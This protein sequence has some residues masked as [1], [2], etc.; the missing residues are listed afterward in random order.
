MKKLVVVLILLLPAPLG[1]WA[2]DD[3]S[4]NDPV[5]NEILRAQQLNSRSWASNEAEIEAGLLKYDISRSSLYPQISAGLDGSGTNSFLS[6]SPAASPEQTYD[7]EIKNNYSFSLTP[8]L[9][10]SQLLP[11]AG[12]LS[13]S[14]SNTITGEGIEESNYYLSPAEDTEYSNYLYF[15]LGLTQPLYFGKAYDAARRQINDSLEISRL[16]WCDSR[17][18]LIIAAVTDYYSLMQSAY[19]LELVQSR[20]TANTEYEKRMRREHSLGMWTSAQLN[21]A[22]AARLQAEADQLKAERAY[23]SA[24][25]RISILYGIEIDLDPDAVDIEM[26]PFSFEIDELRSLLYEGNPE[27][28]IIAKQ[29]SSAEADVILA[30][31]EA[32]WSFYADSSYSITSGISQAGFT[33]SLSLSIGLSMPVVDGNAAKKNIELKKSRAAKLEDDMSEQRKIAAANLQILLDSIELSGKL[34]DIYTLQEETAAFDLEKGGL[35]LELG[36]ITQKELIE[37]QAVLE[38]ARLSILLNK[39]DYNINVLTVYRMLG[40]DLGMLTGISEGA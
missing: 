20:L 16:A 31:K 24:R 33:D 12:T 8:S 17:N 39:I 11:S 25:E 14:F 26:L 40:I 9:A 2:I 13:G 6:T 37:L 19:R 4:F 29:K 28:G 27:S 7:I 36:H 21:T 15:S 3:I 34:N 35:E 10:I 22:T 32:A 30:E 23:T 1:L 5:L 38:N 18:S